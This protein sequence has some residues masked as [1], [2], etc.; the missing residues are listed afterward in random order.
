VPDTLK[1]IGAVEARSGH[2]DEKIPGPNGR[3]GHVVQCQ[4]VRSTGF[5]DDDR[6][7]EHD[8]IPRTDYH[9]PV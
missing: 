5:F 2:P 1:Q 8:R 7:H 9:T 3:I 4:D 6:A